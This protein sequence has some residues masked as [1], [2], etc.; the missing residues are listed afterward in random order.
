L[1]EIYTEV[2]KKVPMHRNLNLK[3]FIAAIDPLLVEEYFVSRVP[4]EE[5]IPY[6]RSM[7]MDY[8]YVKDLMAN[9]KDDQ[10]K[11]KIGGELKQ[12]RDLG[13]RAMDT[14]VRVATANGIPLQEDEPP[15]QLAMRLFLKHNRVFEHAWTL[16][17][18]DNSKTNLYERYV[19]RD[20]I[21]INPEDGDI[22]AFRSQIWDFFNK[23]AKGNSLVKQFDEKDQIALMIVHGSYIKTIARWVADEVIIDTYRPAFEDVALYDK[24]RSVLKIRASRKDQQ[25]YYESFA[26]CILGIP[27][28]EQS[29]ENNVYSLHPLEDKTFNWKGNE[30][31]S[32]IKVLEVHLKIPEST[33]PFIIVKSADV[34]KTFEEDLEDI[35]FSSGQVLYVKFEFIIETDKGSENAIFIINPPAVSDL[36]RSNHRD[37][38]SAYLKENGVLLV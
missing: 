34:K 32:S 7:G 9:L 15:Q 26:K 27:E 38:I 24:A 1:L 25:Q 22:E 33:E 35:D 10:R 2:E 3:A 37:I 17:C 21:N 23:Q 6:L 19:P 13:K 20:S 36:T 4:E 28:P 18:Y 11:G 16:Y 12:M 29:E 14:M 5:L 30:Q 8:G 31:I